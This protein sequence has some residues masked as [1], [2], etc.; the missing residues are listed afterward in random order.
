MVA[1]LFAAGHLR[2][3]DVLHLDSSIVNHEPTI[4]STVPAKAIKAESRILAR[5]RD[6]NSEQGSLPVDSDSPSASFITC[7]ELSHR[8]YLERINIGQCVLTMV[9]SQFSFGV[10]T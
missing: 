2:L 10:S 1:L 3:V 8:P 4:F 9:P 7:Q 5:R 6:R